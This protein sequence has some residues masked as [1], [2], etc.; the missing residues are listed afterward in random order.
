[1]TFQGDIR[2]KVFPNDTLNSISIYVKFSQSLFL[3]GMASCKRYA[4]SMLLP[5]KKKLPRI[6]PK[7]IYSPV[8]VSLKKNLRHFSTNKDSLSKAHWKNRKEFEKK[9][10]QRHIISNFRTFWRN[11]LFWK[12]LKSWH[13]F[14]FV[15]NYHIKAQSPWRLHFGNVW[16]LFFLIVWA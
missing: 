11:L 2:C 1:M 10:F 7:K 14:P 4:P 16:P 13:I 6:F 12:I 9:P 8:L 5:D 15:K 3:T